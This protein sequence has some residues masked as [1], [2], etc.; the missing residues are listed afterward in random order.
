MT[1][2][3]GRGILVDIFMSQELNRPTLDER[4]F[5][6]LI[7]DG[8]QARREHRLDAARKSFTEAMNL[9]RLSLGE[10]QA[11]LAT[12][13]NGLAQAERDLQRNDAALRNY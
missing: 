5:D 8:Y 13:L 12:A 7:R 9:A 1:N 2:A 4:I 3:D 11:A 10:N 6:A